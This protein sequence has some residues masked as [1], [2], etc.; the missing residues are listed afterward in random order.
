MRVIGVAP[1][2]VSLIIKVSQY[3]RL[4]NR[5]SMKKMLLKPMEAA[6]VLGIGRSLMYELIACGDMPSIR[7]G[8]CIR[9]SS[10]AL[11]QWVSDRQTQSSDL[12]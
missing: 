9:I 11:E 7:I 12:A 2:Y 1:I 10:E 4:V 8:R 6:E 5:W 3:F